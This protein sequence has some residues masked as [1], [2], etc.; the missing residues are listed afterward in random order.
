MKVYEVITN[1]IL[2]AL[3]EGTIPWR[4]PWKCGGAPRNLV[5]GNTYRGLNILLTTM[6]GYASPY[7]L[8]FRQIEERGG[9]IR[10]GEKGT[11][12]IF[13]NWQ[14]RQVQA[15]DGEIEGK[16][17]PF[18]RY[19]TVFNLGQIDGLTLPKEIAEETFASIVSCE[20]VIS[21][22]PNPPVIVHGF[23][24]AS[25]SPSKDQVRMPPRASFQSPESYYATLYHEVVHAVGHGSRLGRKGI[26]EKHAFGSPEYSREELIA[27]LG[28]S[29]L[30]GHTGIVNNTIENQAAYIDH[31]RKQLEA[32][33]KLVVYAAAQ[34]QKAVDFILGLRADKKEEAA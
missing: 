20:E 28:A 21:K 33:K 31:W 17:I 26:E 8:T 2:A 23:T 7:W 1:R 32:D 13:W 12:I 34:A 4:K 22:M 29:F 16:D 9:Q 14:T 6:Q 11:P 18:M 15:Q 19:Y 10:K 5:T 25:Y 27:E 24:Q 3:D 30:C